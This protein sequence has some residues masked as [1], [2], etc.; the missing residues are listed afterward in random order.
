MNKE[1]RREKIKTIEIKQKY[2][3][4]KKKKE[5]NERKKYPQNDKKKVKRGR[6][7]RR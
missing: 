2:K 6:I 4:T 7:R 3:K 5:T 1:T